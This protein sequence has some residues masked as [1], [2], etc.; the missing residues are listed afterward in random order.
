MIQLVIFIIAEYP[1]RRIKTGEE[2]FG[3]ARNVAFMSGSKM[4]QSGKGAI[5]GPQPH[6]QRR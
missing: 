2:N 4:A 6:P 3:D 5:H 1:K